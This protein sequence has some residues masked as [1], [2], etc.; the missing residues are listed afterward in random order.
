MQIIESRESQISLEDSQNDLIMDQNIH[1]HS[2]LVRDVTVETVRRAGF[3]E[4][5]VK[6]AKTIVE[7]MKEPVDWFYDL[8]RIKKLEVPAIEQHH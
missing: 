3:D 2:Q 6:A 7:K 4:S 8:F 1:I 5:V